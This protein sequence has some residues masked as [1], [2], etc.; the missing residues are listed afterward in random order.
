MVLKSEFLRKEILE[1]G[2]LVQ[3]IL[4]ISYNNDESLENLL[5]IEEQINQ[6]H[7]HIDDE[8]FK[9]IALQKPAATDCGW[10]WL[11]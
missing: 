9:Y 1:M 3:K 4:N 8:V 10:P 2:N 5:A 11:P 6:K 7:I